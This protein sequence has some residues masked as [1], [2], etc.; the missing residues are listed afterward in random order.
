M[1]PPGRGR[2]YDGLII[3]HVLMAFFN[4]LLSGNDVFFCFFLLSGATYNKATKKNMLSK[5]GQC[6]ELIRPFNEGK[7]SD[8][9]WTVA[10]CFKMLHQLIDLMDLIGGLSLID[11]MDFMGCLSY[12]V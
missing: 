3:I 8:I 5:A 7:I 12:D 2:T 9:S 4:D 6:E 1:A 11:L 10:K